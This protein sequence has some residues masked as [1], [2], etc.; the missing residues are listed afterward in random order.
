M[1]HGLKVIHSSVLGVYSPELVLPGFLSHAFCQLALPESQCLVQLRI[2]TSGHS[3]VYKLHINFYIKL[4][5]VLQSTDPENE[6][7]R[8]SCQKLPYVATC[9]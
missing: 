9:S 4:T 2:F 6:L 3:F 8:V 5:A 1:F 7:P